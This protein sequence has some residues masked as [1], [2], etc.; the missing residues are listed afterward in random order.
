MKLAEHE[1]DDELAT[2][3]KLALLRLLIMKEK[4]ARGESRCLDVADKGKRRLKMMIR[5]GTAPF[6]IECRRWRG[7]EREERTC[8]ECDTGKVE[9]VQHWLMECE[10]WKDEQADFL[11]TD[12]GIT[13]F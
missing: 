11:V 4:G 8:T 10:K 7:L 1:W 12:K 9:D 2:K 5:G 13:G 6:R 3:P